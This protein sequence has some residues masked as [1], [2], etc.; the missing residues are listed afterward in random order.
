MPISVHGGQRGGHIGNVGEHDSVGDEARVFELFLL[1]DGIAALD[2]R[3]AKGDPVEKVVEGLDFGGLG[4]DCPAGLGIG[5]EPQQEQR[6]LDATDF[7]KSPVAGCGGCRWRAFRR[8]TTGGA[9]RA[10]F[11]KSPVGGRGGWGAPTCG[12]GPGG[13]PRPAWTDSTT[14]KTSRACVAMRSQSISALNSAS[15]CR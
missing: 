6:A 1:F 5:D 3:S 2:D 13:V 9:G 11:P 4:T 10:G 8:G 12:G 7:S 15:I 14:W